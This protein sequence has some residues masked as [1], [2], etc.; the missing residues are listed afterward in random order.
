MSLVDSIRK[1]H[2]VKVGPSLAQRIAGR[3]HSNVV[4]GLRHFRE[5]LVREMEPENWTDLQ[6]NVVVFLS[7]VCT[8]LELS[9]SE[10][11]EVLGLEGVLALAGK[12]STRITPTLNRRQVAALACVEKHGS[13]NLSVYRAISPGFSDE[14]YRLD[15]CDLVER[16]FLRR[17]GRNKGTRY[18]L[19]G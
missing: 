7:D 12:L 16:G 8:I 3:H 13:I 4:R 1:L 5:E 9:E 11:A 2:L 19:S 17:D 15:L 14:T 10:R 18:T 6:A